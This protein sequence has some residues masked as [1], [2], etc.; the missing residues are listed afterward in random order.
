MKKVLYGAI[1][2]FLV[3]ALF[4]CGKKDKTTDP[5]MVTITFV[6]YDGTAVD[7]LVVE[8][9][10]SISLNN[11]TTSK[12]QHDFQ[13]WSLTTDGSILP[14]AYTVN[15]NISLHAVFTAQLNTFD[16]TFANENGEIITTKAVTEGDTPSY[17]YTVNDTQEWINTFEG[18]TTTLGGTTAM[19]SLPPASEDATYYAVV[20]QTKQEYTITFVANGGSNTQQI[21]MPYGSLVTEPDNP[22]REGY[23]FVSWA[24]NQSLDTIVEWPFELLDHTTFYASWNESVGLGNYLSTLLGTYEINPYQFVPEQMQAVNN[25]VDEDDLVLDY[26]SDVNVSQINYD[27]FGEQW[28]MVLDN[29]LQTQSFFNILTVVDGLTTTSVAA[30]NDYL[31]S[32]PA[33]ENQYEFM[34]GIYRV[35]ISY[36]NNTMSYVIDYTANI[37]G[38]GEQTVQIA[39]SYHVLTHEKIGRIQIGDA[40]ALK[41]EITGDSYT[42]A[43]R[44][45]GVRRAYF[46]IERKPDD[47]VEGAIFEFLGVDDVLTTV[48]ASQFLITDQYVSV[49]GN[50]AGAMLGFSGVINE[51]YNVNNGKLLGY[52]VRET[53]SAITYNTMWVSLENQ[54]GIQQIKRVDEAN[55]SNPD[56]VYVNQNNDPFIAKTVGG[57]SLKK[58]SRRY[59]IEFR[60]QYFY[61]NEA[62][63]I[64]KVA[65]EVPMLFVQHE[66]MSNL[67]SDIIDNNPYLSDFEWILNSN[68]SDKILSDY[69]TMID[70][71]D[72][73]K[74]NITTQDIL[75]YIGEKS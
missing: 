21:T 72:S 2:I 38:F 25:I 58:A 54:N 17:S 16:I 51:L 12:A 69:G 11:Y 34:E 33:N 74:D 61:T 31:D 20:S 15:S 28:Q 43:I 24:M 32:N 52:S 49:V 64:T 14:N 57:F 39:L 67:N 73:N 71:F 6:T 29:L 55:G 36:E 8:A 70:I 35:N 26:S 53:L 1:V 23:R 50:K 22:T 7:D 9:G 66:Q 27:G 18:W 13:G 75:D 56:T 3:F 30:F 47:S 46:H 63:V 4:A 62:D 44:Y 19:G 48:S 65:V 37:P 40:N 60:T 41:Y 10:S 42:F 45:L 5:E 59:D 68:V